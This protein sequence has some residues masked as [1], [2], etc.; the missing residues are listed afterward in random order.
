MQHK[1]LTIF[2]LIYVMSFSALATSAQ[3]SV[4]LDLGDIPAGQQITITY[5]VSVNETLPEGLQFISN[6]GVVTSSNL[7]G[8]LSD[9]PDTV[10]AF[11]ETR[12]PVGLTL[13]VALL[14]ATGETP[15]WY[16]WVVSLGIALAITAGAVGLFATVRRR[17]HNQLS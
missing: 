2:M 7:A 4:G 11:D 6:Q 1:I 13:G 9:D 12:T 17:N 15:W 14:P 3:G 16:L 8:V 10:A 5:E